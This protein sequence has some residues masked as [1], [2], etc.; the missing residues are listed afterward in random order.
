MARSSRCELIVV[1]DSKLVPCLGSGVPL[2]VEIVPFGWKRCAE[3]LARLGCEARLRMTAG[4]RFVTD[5]GNYILDCRFGCMDDPAML[6]RE[7]NNIPGVMEN[8]LFLGLADLVVVVSADGMRTHRRDTIR[9]VG[10]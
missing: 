10:A 5:E 2:P 7:I 9:Q 6:E 4:V 3:S 8:G 1:D